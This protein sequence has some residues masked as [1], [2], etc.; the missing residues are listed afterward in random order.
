VKA[1]YEP[2]ID[3]VNRTPLETVIPLDTPFVVFVDPS[4]ACNFKCRFCPTSDRDLMKSVGRPWKQ[5]SFDLFKKIADDMTEFPGQVEVLR[6][7][8]DGEPLINKRLADM[9]K[10]AKDVGAS[11]RIDMTT[12]AALLTKDKG[13]EIVNAGLDR[14]NISIYG[15]SNEHYKD[16]S[17]VKLEFERV[18][19]NVRDFY[20][21]RGNCEMLVK[22]NGDTL[23]ETEKEIFLEEFGDYSDKIY[24]EHIMSCWPEFQLRGVEV[25]AQKGLYGQEIKEVNTCPYPFYGLA[26]NSDGLVSVCFLDWSRKLI[27]GDVNKETVQQ[28]WSGKKM[29]SFQ[30]M[31]LEGR[32]KDHPVCGSCGQMTHG[33]PDNIDAY[34]LD[35]LN[36][37]KASGYFD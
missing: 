6:M 35:L 8:K 7:Y 29:R 3:L 32:R 24:I 22:I 5:M 37:M 28:V 27:I 26:I 34:S 30:K 16:F 17:G 23:T 18:L 21:I 10:Y 33:N 20:E 31:F 19:A 14:I 1:K 2:R 15:V 13:K 36:G 11:K 4:D 25:N 12:N 9:I